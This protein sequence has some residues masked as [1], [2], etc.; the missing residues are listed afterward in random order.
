[1]KPHTYGILCGLSA[2]IL[3]GILPLYW[4]QLAD[5]PPLTITSHRV[6]WSVITLIFIQIVRGKLPALL[7]KITQPRILINA[8]LLGS[9]L[10]INWLIYIWAVNNGKVVSIS[11][12]YFILPLMYIVIGYFLLKEA[13]TRMQM[14]AV[15]LAAAGVLVQGISIG[16]L[17]WPALCVAGSFAIYGVTKKKT[18]ADGFSILT[19]ELGLIAPFALAYLY[20][21]DKQ[22]G[23]IW[24]DGSLQSIILI[25]LT[26]AATIS[27]L[28]FFTAAAKRIPL[29]LLGMLQFVAPTGQFLLGLIYFGEVI[30]LTQ[31]I[32]FSLIWIAIIIYSLSRTKNSSIT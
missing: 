16:S 20:E 22:Q 19:I 8:F 25:V 1:M 17:P 21:Q 13:M 29:N 6:V 26:G 24:L 23:N 5:I 18:Q 10:M 12:G 32:A 3:W 31:L 9:L 7:E 28:L 15:G 30:K 11:L 27:P 4:T 2:F 14:I